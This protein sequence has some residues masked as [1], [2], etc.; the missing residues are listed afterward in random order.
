MVTVSACLLT[1]PKRLKLLLKTLQNTIWLLAIKPS[2]ILTGAELADKV[3]QIKSELA[4]ILC[5]GHS[6]L[7]NEEK[8]EA[9]NIKD[10]LRKPIETHVLLECVYR[11]LK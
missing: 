11:L 4:V 3:L 8:A 7:I 6:D 10:F 5:T 2:P 9:M 1:Q